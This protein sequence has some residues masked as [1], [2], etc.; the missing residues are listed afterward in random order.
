LLDGPKN[1]PTNA[2]AI[3]VQGNGFAQGVKTI[4]EQAKRNSEA[5][6][7]MST[8]EKEVRLTMNQLCY[9]SNLL[10]FLAS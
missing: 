4:G 7:N 9:S 5:Y 1:L 10:T 3:F 6:R 2:Y 8:E